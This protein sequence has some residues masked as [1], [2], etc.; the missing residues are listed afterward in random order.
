[1]I[2]RR[3]QEEAQ[4]EAENWWLRF[5]Q[6]VVYCKRNAIIVRRKEWIA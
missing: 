3:R 6:T 1:M 4:I 5:R 2:K